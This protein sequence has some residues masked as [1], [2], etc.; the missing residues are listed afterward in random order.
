MIR[1]MADRIEA[2]LSE[3]TVAE[4]ADLM[5]GRGIWDANGVERL[6]IPALKVTDGPNGARG[7]G[8]LGTGTPALC[9]PC[10]SALG[11]TWD[12]ALVEELGGVLAAETA[13][14]GF[15]VLLAPTVNIHRSPLG[16]RNFECYSEDPH[17]SGS[18]A[19]G[20]V[21][22]VQGG[23]IGTT[24][25]H[26]VANDSEFERTTIDSVVPERALREVYLVPFEMAVREA[27][28]WGIMSSYN[29]INGTYAAEHR[30]LLTDILLDEWG[31]DG[32]VVTDWFARGS[33]VRSAEAGLTLEMPGRGRFYGQRLVEAV[34]AGELDEAVIDAAVRRQLRL[35]ERTGAFDDPR[36][37]PEGQ[38][39]DAGHRALIRRAAADATV[40]FRNDGV[41]PLDVDGL[42][43]LAVIGPNARDAMMMGGGSAALVPQHSTSPLDAIRARFPDLDVRFEPGARTD[44]ST[45]PIPA[46][47]LPDG[48]RL[49][50]FDGG[51]WTGDPVHVDAAD[52]GRL[53]ETAD[54]PGLAAPGDYS[55]RATGTLVPDETGTHHLT[56]VQV[57]RA[58]VSVDGEVLLDGI[59]DPPPPGEA[60]FNLGSSEVS[61]ALELEAGRPVEILVEYVPHG[62]FLFRGAQ[63]GLR[64]PEQ[65]DLVERAVAAA[66]ASDAVVLVVG[67]NDDW[68][69]EGRDRESMD[70][71]G[72]QPEL[73]R[74][75][76][77]AN[78]RTVVVVNAGS[79]VTMD[80]ADEP[81]AV[82][83]AWFG[84]QEMGD[85]LVDVL[86]GD[87]EPGGRL[88]TTVPHRLEDTPA[89][90]NYP[91]ENGQVHYGEGVFVGYRWYEARDLGVRFPFGHG[92]GYATLEWG[93]A[94]LSSVPTVDELA[95]GATVKATVPVTNTGDRTGSEVVQCYVAPLA[96]A[97]ARPPQE[98]RGF[99]KVE[100]APGETVEA[101]VEL[102][103]RAFAYY[104]PAD[105][106]WPD[107]NSNAPVA[108]GGGG[109]GA[110]HRPEPG[111]YADPGDYEVRLGASSADLRAV[112]QVH[113]DGDEGGRR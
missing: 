59:A 22:G 112:L 74:R 64:P 10:G 38:L 20:Y 52:D 94:H 71:P 53:L 88:P 85:A 56:L 24:V 8:L 86:V 7:A 18:I 43:S 48:F 89:F 6:G 79:V 40:L 44:R 84:G 1:G 51:D 32:I 54:P 82:L 61:T 4:K 103:H 99:A 98:L 76:A 102:G 34:E 106:T 91:G 81:A 113:L 67:T 41:L 13:A 75:V 72:D 30:R 63:V 69:T 23:G 55:W 58:R 77:A 25:K 19:A 70:L 104:D 108:A 68:E 87:A 45:R 15:H 35:L 46:R 3:L 5:T 96:P 95:D 27:G 28:A 92:L 93:E 62:A 107:R 49:E 42:D 73:I 39:D 37:R 29:R 16:G 80:W 90:T 105:P 65:D 14:R 26:F 111:W 21:R 57:G 47:L 101:V 2:L 110:G 12:P 97:L 36:D 31:F 83:Q 66:E 17:L 78:P 9:L 33:T 11:A 109:T 60:F 100:V 50:H